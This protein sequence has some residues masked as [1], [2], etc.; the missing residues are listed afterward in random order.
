MD[1]LTDLDAV[2]AI[3]D[4]PFI[5][6][7]VQWVDVQA[8]TR[9][10]TNEAEAEFIKEVLRRAKLTGKMDLKIVSII[11]PYNAQKAMIT[12]SLK[13]ESIE[14]RDICTIDE[15]QG[16]QN[17]VIILS[18]VAQAP[19][20]FLRD[21]RRITVMMSRTRARLIVFGNHAGFA[22]VP[23]WQSVVQAIENANRLTT[24]CID[25]T[26]DRC[27]ADMSRDND[28]LEKRSNQTRKRKD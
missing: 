5:D 13:K 23:E 27:A 19:T 7:V 14:P 8:Q 2:T 15:F 6:R 4:V 17:L 16:Q 20:M 3:P 26:M 10:E 24:L 25:R 12:E 22:A 21:E 11:T 18:L 9:G 28:A 1:V